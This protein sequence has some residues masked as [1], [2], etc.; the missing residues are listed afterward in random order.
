MRVIGQC[1]ITSDIRQKDNHMN[2]KELIADLRSRINPEYAHVNGTESY[3]R[4]I[5]VEALEAQ[6]AEIERLRVLAQSNVELTGAKPAGEASGSAQ[7]YA[8][9]G[10]RDE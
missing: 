2:T 3:E 1:A 8:A 10:R 7:G 4:R 9:K 6:D 5:C